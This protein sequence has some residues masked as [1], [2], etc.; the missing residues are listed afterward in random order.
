MAPQCQDPW[1]WGYE[2]Y[3]LGTEFLDYPNHVLCLLKYPAV[4]LKEFFKEF[5]F[6]Y[7]MPSRTHYEFTVINAGPTTQYDGRKWIAKG[8]PSNLMT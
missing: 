3:S 2:F 1:P 7:L 4:L 5:L 6:V 8:H